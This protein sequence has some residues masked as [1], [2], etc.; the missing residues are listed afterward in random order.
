LENPTTSNLP[1]TEFDELM[2][3]VCIAENTDEH[4]FVSAKQYITRL[5]VRS[6]VLFFILISRGLMENHPIKMLPEY[7]RWFSEKPVQKFIC[8][9]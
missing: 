9:L 2:Y 6:Q 5:P 8:N 4:N 3:V 7:N 1:R